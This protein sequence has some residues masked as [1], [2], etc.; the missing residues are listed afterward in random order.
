MTNPQ[1]LRI[2]MEQS[3]KDLGCQAEDFIRNENVVV[4]FALGPEAKRYYK[5]PI[6]G[7]FISYG[8]N[9]VAAATE[10][11]FSAVNDYVKKFAFYHC[12]ETPGILWLNERL[13]PVGQTVCFGRRE[14]NPYRF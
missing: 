10:D 7:N 13:E 6:G 5:L 12:F 8:N 11:C 9:V 3:A 2:A 14:S 1:I 4:P